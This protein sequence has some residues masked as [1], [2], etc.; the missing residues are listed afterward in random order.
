[1]RAS[2]T[3]FFLVKSRPCP[4]KELADFVLR[5][6]GLQE[7]WATEGTYSFI[8]RFQAP[9]G[10]IPLLASQLSKHKAILQLETINAPISFTP[11]RC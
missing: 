6:P 5:F 11:R 9:E 4:I 7:V 2:E 8:A 1:V 10:A 3:V